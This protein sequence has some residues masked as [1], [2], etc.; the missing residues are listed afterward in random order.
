MSYK[1]ADVALVTQDVALET[2]VRRAQPAELR[3]EHVDA[4]DPQLVEGRRAREW[5][6]DLDCVKEAP[7]SD[8]RRIYF[9][10]AL[11]NGSPRRLP[12]GLFIRKP[13]TRAMMSTLWSEA[14]L[15]SGG[16]APAPGVLSG[17]HL[18]GWLVAFH[19]LDVRRICHR[20]VT[21]LPA[22]LG[23]TEVALYLHDDARGALTLAESNCARGLELSLR[24]DKPA[25]Q[26]VADVAQSRRPIVADDLAQAC[27]RMGLAREKRP[28]RQAGLIAPLVADSELVG[29]VELVGRRVTD[30]T[31]LGLS[32]E[33]VCSFVARCLHHARLFE[34]AQIEARLDCLTGLHNRRW[35]LETV[36]QEIRRAQRFHRPL[37]LAVLDVNGLKDVNDRFGHVVGDAVLRHVAGRIRSVLRQTDSAARVGGDEFILALSGTDA[38]GAE[39]VCARLIDTLAADGPVHDGRPLDVSASVGIAQWRAGW[40]GSDLIDAADRAMYSS[41]AENRKE[42]VARRVKLIHEAVTRATGTAT[43]AARRK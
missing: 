18:P 4:A 30:E 5:W 36:A 11:R 10:S 3:L 34:T 9:Y 31:E 41:K 29:V 14:H 27:R 23:Y 8:V 20:C 28:A 25:T 12:R 19:D 22:R 32:L 1:T 13:C 43:P 15:R 21:E 38:A 42:A 40:T 37:S 39:L 7:D 17:S 24:L 33:L 2:L 16:R 35:A 6:L 26:A